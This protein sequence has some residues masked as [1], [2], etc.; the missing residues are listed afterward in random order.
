LAPVAANRA[1]IIAAN[2][3]LAA[4]FLP[5]AR[6]LADQIGMTWPSVLEMATKRYLRERLGLVID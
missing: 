6:R 3:E 1:G 4:I 5:R 2:T